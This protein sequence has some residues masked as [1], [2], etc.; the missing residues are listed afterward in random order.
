MDKQVSVPQLPAGV[1]EKLGEIGAIMRGINIA[2]DFFDESKPWWTQNTNNH[3]MLMF[4]H[5]YRSFERDPEIQVWLSPLIDVMCWM[6]VNNP[7]Y[8]ARML[9]MTFFLDAYIA[10]KQFIDEHKMRM[11]LETWA[12]PRKWGDHLATRTMPV[13]E[14]LYA[15]VR[16]PDEVVR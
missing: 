14:V 16:N 2:P 3:V 10:D 8:R 1:Q 9:W 12:D 7:A 5:Y 11:I 15:Q 13:P 4:R 6:F